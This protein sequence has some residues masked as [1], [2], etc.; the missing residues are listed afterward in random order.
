MPVYAGGLSTTAMVKIQVTD[1]NDNR[2]IF[3]PRAYNVSLHEHKSGDLPVVVVAATDKDAG[4][5][6]AVRYAIAS[7]ND[8]GVFR[9]DASS[10]E[11]FVIRSLSRSR[12]MHRLAISATDGGGLRSLHDAEILVT[13]I[14][15]NHRPPIFEKNR[16]LFS[17][18]ED[19]PLN[20][21]IGSVKAVSE[22]GTF[23]ENLLA[24]YINVNFNIRIR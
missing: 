3:Y 19:V 22:T 10:G 4:Q 24:A 2:P 7:G 1:V 8:D 9:I 16:Y 21:N 12:P 14:D 18:R 13:V 23:A 17:I 11:V 6:G 15:N 5:Y 20:T